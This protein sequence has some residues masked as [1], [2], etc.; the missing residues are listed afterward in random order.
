MCSVTGSRDTCY[1]LDSRGSIPG[2]GKRFFSTPQ[3]PNRLLGLPSFYM[4]WV[5]GDK[6]AGA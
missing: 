1:R 2:R 6:V 5:P 4:K 3:R